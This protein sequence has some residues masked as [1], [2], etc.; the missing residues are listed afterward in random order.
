MTSNRPWRKFDGEIPHDS[1]MR[2]W[3]RRADELAREQ[4]CKGACHICFRPVC[5]RRGSLKLMAPGIYR[6]RPF[7]VMLC[8]AC[9]SFLKQT[10][11]IQQ[12]KLHRD[13]LAPEDL[14]G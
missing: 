4:G 13:H 1:T 7:E 3:R 9:W 6:Q 5:G 8:T 10:I 12:T 14:D 2:R 11:L